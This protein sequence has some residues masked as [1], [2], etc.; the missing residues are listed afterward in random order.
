MAQRNLKRARVG[1]PGGGEGE[2]AGPAPAAHPGRHLQL[3]TT[4]P[5]R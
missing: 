5:S 3:P 2:G 4:K 1:A